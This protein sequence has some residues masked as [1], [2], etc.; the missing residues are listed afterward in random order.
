MY[1]DVE[2]LTDVHTDALL[3]PKRTLIYDKDQVFVYRLK[4]ERRVE[5]VLVEPLLS[6][7]DNVEPGGDRLAAG[8]Q[9][10]SAG[11]AGLK[12]GALVRLPG[13]PE[14]AKSGA[15]AEDAA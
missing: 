15:V 6:D 1:V 2:L 14:P 4:E 11:Q 7:R 5:R 10:V 8:D 9:V 3:L 12:D 13:D